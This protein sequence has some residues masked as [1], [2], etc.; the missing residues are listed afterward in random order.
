MMLSTL[1]SQKLEQENMSQE[2]SFWTQSQQLLMRSELGPTDNSSTQSNS[3]LARK[4][5]PTISPE[6]TTQSVGKSSTFVQTEL[7]NQLTT[8]LDSKDSLSSV[9]SEEVLGLV[10]DLF[11][12]RDSRLT[13]VKN[14]SWVSPSILLLRSLLLQSNLTILSFL[15][16]L[17]WNIL[18]SP[19]CQTTRPSM[20]S[21]EDNWTS[22][23]P[24][25][26]TLTDWLPRSSPL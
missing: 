3:Y 12:Q 11:Y 23:D 14:P 6:V 1:S 18:T 20:T 2:V 13:M 10:W 26:P 9:P 4:M 15:P 17:F 24:L 19:S 7:E 22:R 21:A 8:V 25:I 16:T 5:L